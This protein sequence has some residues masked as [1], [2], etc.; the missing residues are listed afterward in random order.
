MSCDSLLTTSLLQVVYTLV[1]SWL[2]KLVITG[3]PRKKLL[4]PQASLQMIVKTFYSQV[5]YKLQQVCKWQ[6]ATRLVWNWQLSL[7]QLVGKLLQAGKIYDLQQVRCVFCVCTVP[8]GIPGVNYSWVLS[9]RHVQEPWIERNLRH[10][11]QDAHVQSQGIY[12]HL[13]L[14]LQTW[15]MQQFDYISNSLLLFERKWMR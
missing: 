7:L 11:E 5:C 10:E 15:N 4:Q 1:A 14:V 13:L 12:P 9:S 6:A 2:S 8:G 3:V